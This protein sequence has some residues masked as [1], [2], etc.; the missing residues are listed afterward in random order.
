MRNQSYI[1]KR[2]ILSLIWEWQILNR[3]LP[4]TTLNQFKWKQAF[5]V[6]FMSKFFSAWTLLYG[7]S[8]KIM[9]LVFN[10]S[11]ITVYNVVHAICMPMA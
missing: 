5:F 11:H 7:H 1:L 9:Q 8:Y 2:G 3:S 4:N 6:N 10:A